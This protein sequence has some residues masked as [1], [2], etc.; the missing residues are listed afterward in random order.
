MVLSGLT[1][2]QL[3]FFDLGFQRRHVRH[4]EQMKMSSILAK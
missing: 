3:E 2:L 1:Y 4:G